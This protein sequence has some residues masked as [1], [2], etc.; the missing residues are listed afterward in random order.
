MR[1]RKPQVPTRDT[2]EASSIPLYRQM[3]GTIDFEP[4]LCLQALQVRY[5]YDQIE[6]VPNNEPYLPPRMSRYEG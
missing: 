5:D 4:W 1:P 2:I 6:R 3:D